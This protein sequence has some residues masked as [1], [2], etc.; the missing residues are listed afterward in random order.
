LI[1]I[2]ILTSIGIFGFTLLLVALTLKF[3][4]IASFEQVI[5]FALLVLSGS[6]VSRIIAVD[7]PYYGN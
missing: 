3:T 2:F 6:I 7:A 5:A 1:L 4:K